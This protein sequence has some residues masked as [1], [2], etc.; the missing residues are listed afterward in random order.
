MAGSSALNMSMFGNSALDNNIYVCEINRSKFQRSSGIFFGENPLK[1]TLPVI[2]LQTCLVGLLTTILQLLLIPHGVTNFPPRLLAGL[3]MGP[4]ILGEIDLVRKYLFPP[5]TYYINDTIAFFGSMMYMFVIGI[6]IDLSSVLKSLRRGKRAWAIGTCSLI[7]PLTLSTTSAILLRLT[8]SSS[9]EKLYSTIVPTAV[10][11]STTSFHVT[12]SHLADLKLLNSDIGRI[13]V[14]S[15][16]VGGTLSAILVTILFSLRQSKLRHDNSFSMMMGSLIVMAIFIAYVLRPIM[17][18]MIRQT[19]KGKPVKESYIVSVFF[20]LLG[21]AYIGESIGEHFMIGP[22]L[23]GLAVPDGPP[24]ASALVEKLETMVSSV[25][26]P[27]YFLYS[28]SKFKVFLIDAPSFA[29]VQLVAFISLFGKVIGTMLPSIYCKM[30]VVDALCLGLILSARGITELLYFQACLHYLVMDGQ[31]YGNIVIALLW[32]TG[33]TTPIVRYLYDPSKG[34]LS[35]NRRRNIQHAS[36]GVELQLMACIYSEEN[37]PSIINI[38]EMS[39]STHESPICFHVLHLIQLTGRA[40]PLFIDHQ[41]G[42]KIT[43]DSSVHTT[44]SQHIVNAFRLYE[45]QNL[46]TVVVKIFT[47]ISPYDTMHDEICMQAAEKRVSMLIVPFHRQWT[48]NG[49][50]ESALPI[51]ALNRHLLRTA[52]C[53]VGILIER[54]ALNRSSAIT[55]MS[56]Y[57]VGV[58]F[59]EG[60]DDREALVYAMRMAERLNVRVTVVRLVEPRRMKNRVLMNRDSDANLIDKFK[61]DYTHIKR[62]DYKE[63]IVRDSVEV[64]NVVRSLEGCFDLILVGRRH[65]SESSSLFNGLTEWNEYPELGCVGDM[66]VCSDSTF[67]GSVL[68]IQQQKLGAVH[69]VEYVDSSIINTKQEPFTVVEMPHGTKV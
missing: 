47:S 9:E 51:R 68:V 11:I 36:P 61:A 42:D 69:H 50:S 17:I 45:E 49:V 57:S 39:N 66:L 24:L 16:I 6:K 28:G 2:V 34:Y 63:E 5:R 33:L 60:T 67:D 8:L 13:G 58:I 54:G 12:S 21:C 10:L 48:I 18:W 7:I 38:L 35:L 55:C 32:M 62:H 53:S 29:V 27:L 59:I 1:F 56:F 23:L 4:S 64:I 3:I 22:I 14:S 46:G 41:L 26:L 31:S 65:A 40:T 44:Q 43:S 37:S 15:S 30:P 19:P 52:P 25:F 20:M